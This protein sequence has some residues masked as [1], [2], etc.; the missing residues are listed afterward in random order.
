MLPFKTR[1]K[2]ALLD[3]FV[4][5][6]RT[7]AQHNLSGVIAEIWMQETGESRSSAYRWAKDARDLWKRF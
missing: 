1:C 5:G 7:Y 3:A 6:W 2:I 4:P